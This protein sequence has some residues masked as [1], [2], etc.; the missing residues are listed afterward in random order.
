MKSFSGKLQLIFSVI[1]IV[2]CCCGEGWG[3]NWREYFSTDSSK[4]YYDEESFT[5]LSNFSITIRV[6]FVLTDKGVMSATQ[7]LGKEYRNLGHT[8]QLMAINCVDHTSN[9][10]EAIF[11]SK[12]G[13]IISREEY[14]YADWRSIPPKTPHEALLKV[15]CKQTKR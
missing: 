4:Y 3:V 6:K 2:M 7:T 5:R 15:V 9:I 12:T 10:V 8:V 1:G 14:P 13:D 11:Y